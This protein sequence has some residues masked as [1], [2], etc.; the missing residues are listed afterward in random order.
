VKTEE[1]QSLETLLTERP[2]VAALIRDAEAARWRYATELVEAARAEA[3]RTWISYPTPSRD[4][5]VVRR[6]P[7]KIGRR[8]LDHT[9]T[10]GPPAT[11]K[12]SDDAHQCS[13]L[14]SVLI[15]VYNKG[16]ILQDALQSVLSQ[17]MTDVEVLI[18]ND[19]S[20]DLETLDTFGDIERHCL[21]LASPPRI[22]TFSWTNSGVVATRNALASE[23]SGKYLCFLDPDDRLH[24][25][26]LEKLLLAMTQEPSL[27]VCAPFTRVVSE[28]KQWVWEV[29]PLDPHAIT[30]GNC[31][32]VVSLI[33]SDWFNYVGGFAEAAKDGFEDWELWMRLAFAGGQGA[34]VPDALWD[35]S[36]SETEGRWTWLT[37]RYE[38]N[39]RDIKLLNPSRLKAPGQSPPPSVAYDWTSEL[40]A[41]VNWAIPQGTKR[42]VVFFLPWLTVE[43]GA[44]KFIRDLGALLRERGHTV[45]F[46]ATGNAPA[47]SRDG[48]VAFQD[49]SPYTYRLP[50][51]LAPHHWTEWTKALLSRFGDP[52]MINVGSHWFYEQVAGEATIRDAG[53]KRVDI[54][55]NPIG[56]LPEFLEKQEFFTDVVAAYDDLAV[57]LNSYF[58][59]APKVHTIPVGI[60]RS[61]AEDSDFSF[62]ATE[63]PRFG[64]LGRFSEEKCPERFIDLA[65]MVGSAAEFHMAGGGP[66]HARI[67]EQVQD[68]PNI[69]LHGFVDD[70][71]QFL[72]GV[73][74]LVNTSRIEGIPLTIMEAVSLGT[75]VV[76]P[77]VGGI[78]DVI[79][80]GEN[81]FLYS[82]EEPSSVGSLLQALAQDRGR[83][84]EL[85]KTTRKSGLEPRFTDEAMAESYATLLA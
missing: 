62:V 22:K 63:R 2:W 25:T 82:A 76:A 38:E 39:L 78:R 83:L 40:L 29:P 30:K 69:T 5:D 59:V 42:P 84:E 55:F 70:A 6:L 68:V 20:S 10:I 80:D 51:I 57:L 16:R 34:V 46:V 65:R 4:R 66:L 41:K 31:L 7:K 73:D 48:Y 43:G 53:T 71:H 32:P 33:R 79:K 15:P 56:H 49:A 21:T 61:L 64:W 27:A 52:A 28:S 26:F 58:D 85:R 12:P 74:L 75:P 44:E 19:G 37:Q 17:T 36:A 8:L 50:E 1:T 72:S 47:G 23:A 24:P 14:V 3:Y 67:E 60:G 9:R 54:L 13:P 35:Y 77:S 45:A 18:W 11:P 81:G